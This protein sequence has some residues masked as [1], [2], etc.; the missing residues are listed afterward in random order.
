MPVVVGFLKREDQILLGRRPK[1]DSLAGAWEFPG[2]KVKEGESPPTALARELYEELGIGEV[3]VGPL[4]LAVTHSLG[5]V[6]VLILF[7]SISSWSGE[8]QA[9]Y[10]EDLQWVNKNDLFHL[11]IPE[12]NKIHLKEIMEALRQCPKI[13]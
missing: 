11:N 13:T 7:Y 5:V 2:G 12:A 9:L 4:G 6:N 3:E 8:P 1:G 10:H